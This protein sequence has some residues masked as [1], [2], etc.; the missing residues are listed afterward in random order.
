MFRHL[1][2]VLQSSNLRTYASKPLKKEVLTRTPLISCKLRKFDQYVETEVPSDA[3][4]GS[5]PLASSGWHHHKSKGDHFTIHAVASWETHDV[6]DRSFADM[7]LDPQI[8]ENLKLRLD[9]TKPSNIQCSAFT[10]MLRGNHT[11]IAAET[12]C[13]KTLAYLIPIVQR[14]LSSK[15]KLNGEMNTPTVLI[16]TPG[17]ELG[18]ST[19]NS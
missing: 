15:E 13:G 9:V 2:I 3:K 11:L 7:Q 6:G 5:I 18:K 10:P 17:R 19:D 8:I 16:L 12:G 1:K 4:F 14:I